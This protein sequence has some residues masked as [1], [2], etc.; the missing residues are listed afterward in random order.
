LGDIN[1]NVGLGS[2]VIYGNIEGVSW[3]SST[4]VVCVSDKAKS[5]QPAYQTFKDQSVH[6]FNIP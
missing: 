6:I 2:Y 5:D 1:G 4:Q 3:I